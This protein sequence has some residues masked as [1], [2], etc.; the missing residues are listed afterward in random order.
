MNPGGQCPNRPARLTTTFRIQHPLPAFGAAPRG[1]L[2]VLRRLLPCLNPR[3]Q[4][5]SQSITLWLK[6]IVLTRAFTIVR[7]P[8]RLAKQNLGFWSLHRITP[9]LGVPGD[10]E[11]RGRGCWLDGVVE[12]EAD[13]TRHCRPTCMGWTAVYAGCG[14]EKPSA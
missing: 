5:V 12:N 8:R 7:W 3:S 2:D 9:P 14:A 4:F 10:R 6:P 1:T 11:K 13:A